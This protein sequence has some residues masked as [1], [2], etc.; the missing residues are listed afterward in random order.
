MVDAVVSFVVERV[1]DYLIREAV[2]LREVRNEVE[3][4]MNELKWMQCFIK[5][6][7]EKQSD[8]PMIGMWISDLRDIAYDSEDVLDKFLLEVENEGTSGMPRVD[9]GSTSKK[10]SRF[11]ASI[12]KSCSFVFPKGS[13]LVNKGKEKMKL[14][15]IG[16]EIEAL[17]RR[18]GDLSLNREKYGLKDINNQR[19]A[20]SKRKNLE[21]LRQL[22]RAPSFAVEQNVVGFEDDAKKLLAKLL[23][24]EPRRSVISIFGMGGLGKTTLARRLYHDVKDNFHRCAWVCVSQDYSTQDLLIRII[25]SFEFN[26]ETKELKE[27]NEEDLE[28]FLYKSLQASSYLVVVDDVWEKEVWKSLKRAFPENMNKS[29]VIIT[30]RIKEVAESSDERIHFHKLRFLTPDESWKLFHNKAFQELDVDEELEKVGR[31]MVQKC[32]GLPL[33]IIVLAGLLSIKEPEEWDEVRQHIWQRLRDDSIHINYLLALSFNDLSHQLKLC[34]LYLGLFPED[35]EI[36]VEELIRLFVAEGF[37]APHETQ[38]MEDVARNNLDYLINRSLIQVEKRYWGRIATC[39]VHDLLRDL[40]IQKA[41]ELNLIHIHDEINQ[42]ISSS[43]M[44]SSRR[45]AVYSLTENSS[46]L[47][48]SNP[49]SRSLFFF[50]QQLHGYS[51]R[52]G[53]VIPLLPG[54][55]LLRVLNLYFR[56]SWVPDEIGK[57]IHLKHLGLSGSFQKELPPSIVNLRRLQTLYVC[58]IDR[59]VELPTDIF[60]LKELRHLVGNFTGPLHIDNLTNLQTLK[61][62]E[63]ESW[64]KVNTEKLVDLR[65]LHLDHEDWRIEKEDYFTFDS[66]AKLRSLQV[67]SIQIYL[68]FVSLEPLRHCQ[69]LKDL[70]L[71]G[72]IEKLPGDMR[73]LLPNLQCLELR[74]FD[75]REDPMPSLGKLPKLMILDLYLGFSGGKKLMIYTA[76]GFPRLEILELAFSDHVEEWQVE[77]GAFPKL[78]GLSLHMP[79]DSNLKIPEKLRSVP[80]PGIWKCRGNFHNDGNI[81]WFM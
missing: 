15:S 27:M 32:R 43:F 69:Y 51:P 12:K 6:A 50:D 78:R 64:T 74:V 30:T 21:K 44:A 70:R 67:L 25:R 19:E 58:A 77:D 4:L 81:L 11:L 80:P 41:K 20:E 55:R 71:Q 7:E 38:T 13:G 17:K 73:A 61:H 23:E 60:K 5:D 42:S 63:H 31:E 33:A 68:S 26:I 39:R 9:E 36:N 14:Y 54:F 79:N 40:A 57:L 22:R 66:I 28:R 52:G 10:S 48:H 46:W 3:S 37:I 24:E 29:R 47:R 56:G 59:Y 62:I 35:Y 8:N 2:F 49:L 1:G 76:K 34:F 75:L 16:K 18:L 72:N 65:E 53:L 45:E